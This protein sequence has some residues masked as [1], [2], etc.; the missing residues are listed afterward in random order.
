MN[1]QASAPVSAL[2]AGSRVLLSLR[3]V[4][5]HA[6]GLPKAEVVAADLRALH[7]VGCVSDDD[8]LRRGQE[9]RRGP[10]CGLLDL[11]VRIRAGSERLASQAERASLGVSADCPSLTGVD[12]APTECCDPLQRVGDIDHRE[13][14]QR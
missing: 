3:C 9:G 14:G 10:R 2:R 8:C 1:S 6:L 11:E 13:V 7:V 4:V 5:L 12:D